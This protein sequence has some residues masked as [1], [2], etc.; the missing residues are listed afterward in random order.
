MKGRCY[1][2]KNSRYKNYGGRGITV[3]AEWINDFEAF[4]T[5]AMQNGY[6]DELSIDRIELDG[7]YEPGNCRFSDKF[8]QA[9]NKTNTGISYKGLMSRYYRG[10]TEERLTERCR[11]ERVG[12]DG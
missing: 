12:A 10:D 8:T 5:W 2:P 6:S 11:R 4:Y 1:N 7:N 3:C 9:R